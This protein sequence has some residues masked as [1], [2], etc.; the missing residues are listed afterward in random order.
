MTRRDAVKK[1]VG[2]LQIAWFIIILAVSPVHSQPITM[3]DN[4]PSWNRV[5]MVFLGDGYTNAD[6]SGGTYVNHINSYL[7]YMFTPNL[8]SDPF[9][10]YRNYFNVYRID[11]VS[12]E[13]GADVPPLGIFRDTALDASYYYDGVT[14]RLLYINQNE[15]NT[16]LADNLAD[17]L[18]TAEMRLVTVNDTRY[19]GGGGYFAVY[20]GGNASANDAA[21]HELAHSF[22]GLADEY[23]G[24]AG[25][26]T[27]TE[28]SEINVTKD[29]TGAKWSQWLGYNQPGI[30]VI[31]TYEGARYYDTGLYRPSF[32]S[33]MRQLGQPF[34]AIAREDII[35]DIYALTNPLDY[36]RNNSGTL[37]NP[38]LLWVECIDEEIIDVEWYI[39]DVLV[40]GLSGERFIV[41]NYLHDPGIYEIS[42]RAFD[43]TGFDPVNGWVRRN[44]SSLEQRID[45]TVQIAVPEPTTLLLLAAGLGGLALVRRKGEK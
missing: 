40:S 27:G 16:V 19:G 20:A 8:L 22:S 33:K 38:R 28:P 18:F 36:W 45:W 13:S 42:A 3:I 11:V 9:S 7:N 5:D 34:D 43:P 15:A 37:I 10:R 14:E 24:N 29:P 4:G 31:D 41:S 21:M 26:Y 39:N 6:I 32:A 25:P 12:N 30:G 44:T 17:A 35:L 1:R 2:V 23:G